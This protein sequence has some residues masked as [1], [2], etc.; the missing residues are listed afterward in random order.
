MNSFKDFGL[1]YSG[2]F[3]AMKME[4]A[5]GKFTAYGYFLSDEQNLIDVTLQLN[6]VV[7]PDQRPPQVLLGKTWPIMTSFLGF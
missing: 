5:D 4:H 2:H 7:K 1:G 3:M 6:D